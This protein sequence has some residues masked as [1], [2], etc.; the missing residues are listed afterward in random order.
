MSLFASRMTPDGRTVTMPVAQRTAAPAPVVRPS[1]LTAQGPRTVSAG[2]PV[3]S[4]GGG[5][6]TTASVFNTPQVPNV[7][8]PPDQAPQQ[9]T[10]SSDT[11]LLPFPPDAV[12]A[13]TPFYKKWWFWV[14]VAGGTG[15]GYYVYKKRR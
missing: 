1:F 3:S 14:L 2:T 8:P 5:T 7:P 13:T 6:N 12:P 4:N 11:D 15:T 9:S 10:V